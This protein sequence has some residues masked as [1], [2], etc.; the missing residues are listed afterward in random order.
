MKAVIDVYTIVV[1][2]AAVILIIAAVF[3]YTQIIDA[4]LADFLSSTFAGCGRGGQECCKNDWC[5]TGFGCS[6]NVC[7]EDITYQIMIDESYLIYNNL[8]TASRSGRNEFF[9][10]RTGLG[11]EDCSNGQ[12]CQ[13]CHKIFNYNYATTCTDCSYCD[14]DSGTCKNCLACDSAENGKYGELYECYDCSNCQNVLDDLAD[15]CSQCSFCNVANVTTYENGLTCSNCFQCDE[16]RCYSCYDCGTEDYVCDECS[17]TGP[18]NCKIRQD[19]ELCKKVIDCIAFNEGEACEI[20]EI[21]PLPWENGMRFSSIVSNILTNCLTREAKREITD[22]ISQKICSY[23]TSKINFIQNEQSFVGPLNY[24]R[25][26]FTS[27]ES[28]PTYSSLLEMLTSNRDFNG[29]TGEN[30]GILFNDCGIEKIDSTA[31]IPLGTEIIYSND[32][33]IFSPTNPTSTPRTPEGDMPVNLKI[34]VSNVSWNEQFGNDC[35]YNVY[36][37]AQEAIATSED[38]H[39]LYLYRNFSYFNESNYNVNVQFKEWAPS[40][41]NEDPLVQINVTA[42]KYPKLNLNLSGRNANISHIAKAFIAGLR[43]YFIFNSDYN[44]TVNFFCVNSGLYP[45]WETCYENNVSVLL[46]DNVPWKLE[47]TSSVIDTFSSLPDFK[48]IYYDS[49]KTSYNMDFDVELTFFVYTSNITKLNN[50]ILVSPVLVIT[51]TVECVNH[52]ECSQICS[53]LCPA[54]VYGCCF[55][56]KLGQCQSGKCK[57]VDAYAYCSSSPPYQ[58]GSECTTPPCSSYTSSSACTSAGCKWCPSYGGRSTNGCGD[59]CSLWS[60]A[61]GYP[62]CLDLCWNSGSSG[63]CFTTAQC[64]DPTSPTP[65]CTWSDS[66]VGWCWGCCSSTNTCTI[67]AANCY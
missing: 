14:L 49:S 26:Y 41:F 11:W 40:N 30:K 48:Y 22:S 5:A 62:T 45:D 38:D 29:I 12:N 44:R 67:P 24:L 59:T 65:S 2:A 36:L 37:C 28:T 13:N 34:I 23:D 17:G 39:I 6:G 55:G 32:P 58:K 51:P 52:D 20:E 7:I 63:E 56:C 50:T 66:Y 57:C 31:S 53:S 46:N 60:F 3:I 64:I 15:S 27:D 9:S 25:A 35:S 61:L 19:Y 1:I 10:L 4:P 42:I 18:A 21:L 33:E 47:S 54:D 8:E 43:E 16:T